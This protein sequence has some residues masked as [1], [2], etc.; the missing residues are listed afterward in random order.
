MKRFLIIIALFFTFFG[1]R[2]QCRIFTVLDS[3]P[4]KHFKF[5]L[6]TADTTFASD[7][8]GVLLINTQL[9]GYKKR[10]QQPVTFSFH[11][12][13]DKNLYLVP[14]IFK[15]KPVNLSLMCQTKKLVI[16]RRSVN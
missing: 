11:F 10:A 4:R 15:A 6:T 7:D 13:S 1:A 9:A 8:N 2:A 5:A 3:N 12:F 14:A 16:K